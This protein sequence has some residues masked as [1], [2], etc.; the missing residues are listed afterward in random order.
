[1]WDLENCRVTGNYMGMFPVAGMVTES[2]VKYGGSV[3]HT[4]A[5]DKPITVF[6]AIR[7]CVILDNWEVSKIYEC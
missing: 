6:G 4:V 7:E 1:M 2:R 5:L 3:S